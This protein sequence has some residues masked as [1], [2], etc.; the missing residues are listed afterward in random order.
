MGDE[1]HLAPAGVG[2]TSRQESSETTHAQIVAIRRRLRIR[3]G[4]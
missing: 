3:C 2:E 1:D 4:Y